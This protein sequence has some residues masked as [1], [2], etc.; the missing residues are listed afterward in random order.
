MSI[1]DKV[2]ESLK[3]MHE[4]VQKQYDKTKEAIKSY[5]PYQ[6]EKKVEDAEKDIAK[7]DALIQEV[8][9]KKTEYE[10]RKGFAEKEKK[11]AEDRLKAHNE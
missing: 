6:L 9:F 10:F 7:F 4:E 3:T 8:E 5:K 2:T 1:K 11:L